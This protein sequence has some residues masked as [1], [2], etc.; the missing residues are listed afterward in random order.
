MNGKYRQ[1]CNNEK[2]PSADII[3]NFVV[4]IGED[5][6][7]VHRKPCSLSSVNEICQTMTVFET[8][9]TKKLNIIKHLYSN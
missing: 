8:A 7:K 3:S 4:N 2:L 9:S 6:A 5:L 1:Q